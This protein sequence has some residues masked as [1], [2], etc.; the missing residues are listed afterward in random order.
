MDVLPTWGACH[1]VIGLVPVLECKLPEPVYSL[2]S[3]SEELIVGGVGSRLVTFEV[4]KI[5]I[6]INNAPRR[7]VE[8]P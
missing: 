6:M 5:I 2:A 4:I 3:L 1:A 7:D 8:V